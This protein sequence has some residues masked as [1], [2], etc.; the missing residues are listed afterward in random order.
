MLSERVSMRRREFIAAAAAVGALSGCTSEPKTDGEV[1]HDLEVPYQG[2]ESGPVVRVFG[3]YGCHYCARY[4]LQQYPRVRKELIDPGK[5]RYEHYDWPVPVSDWS[6]KV[7]YVARW[8]QAEYGLRAYWL[9]HSTV[10]TYMGNYTED[11]LAALAEQV[12][13][14]KVGD[15]VK[16]A[17]GGEAYEDTILWEKQHGKEEYGVKG[18]PYVFVGDKRVEATA[19]AIS[20]EI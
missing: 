9:F 2:N 7:A 5:I 14:E 15:G 20:N 8:L 11:R 17:I 6:M 10:F 1:T 12:T 18:T 13:G 4:S 19:E 3:D 16:N